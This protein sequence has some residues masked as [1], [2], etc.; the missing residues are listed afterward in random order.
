M[1]YISRNI[2]GEDR[3]WIKKGWDQVYMDP[4]KKEGFLEEDKQTHKVLFIMNR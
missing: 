3:N 1:E 4:I 2:E